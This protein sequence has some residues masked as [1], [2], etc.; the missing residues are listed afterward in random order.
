VIASSPQQARLAA[1]PDSRH[2][3]RPMHVAPWNQ[4]ES[5]E[6]LKT[7]IFTTGR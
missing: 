1:G 4:L 2:G 5:I 3:F 6:L 7:R